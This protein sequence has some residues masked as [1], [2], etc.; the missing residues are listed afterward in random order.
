MQVKKCTLNIS[1]CCVFTCLCVCVASPCGQFMADDATVR[2]DF[3]QTKL[4]VHFSL[5][6]TK[7]ETPVI[8]PLFVHCEHSI[9]FSP[10]QSFTL[11]YRKYSWFVSQDKFLL[12]LKLK[13]TCNLVTWCYLILSKA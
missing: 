2:D 4:Q 11:I 9:K 1:I 3:T 8:S 7:T 13:P 6:D 5:H 10:L 12:N